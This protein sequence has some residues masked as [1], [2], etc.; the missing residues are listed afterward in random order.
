[1]PLPARDLVFYAALSLGAAVDAACAE[2]NR[3]TLPADPEALTHFATVTRGEIT[4]RMATTPEAI[5]AAG[6]G[7]PLPDG[8]HVI[9]IDRRQGAVHRYLVMQKGEGWGE[10]HAEAD[11]TG[12][13]RFQ[14]FRPDGSINMEEDTAR[15]R[16]CHSSRDDRSFMFTFR[17]LQ[18][19][20]RTGEVR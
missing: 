3:V 7:E 2:P 14:W 9:L 8:T 18:T 6:R 15:C 1:M 4:E 12:D 17:D 19:F 11:R 5:A 16:S 20:A 13:W 10:D